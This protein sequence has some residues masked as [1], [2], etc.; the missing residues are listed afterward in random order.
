MMIMVT[1]VCQAP[2]ALMSGIY[3]MVLAI[4][5][6]ATM[7]AIAVSISPLLLMHFFVPIGDL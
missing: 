4:A 2:S 3:V 5:R 7:R 6:I 1:S